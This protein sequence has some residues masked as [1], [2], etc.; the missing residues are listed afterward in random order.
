M[1]I[2]YGTTGLELSRDVSRAEVL[3]SAI[4]ALVAEGSGVESVK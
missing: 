3:E 4:G 1:R 2:P